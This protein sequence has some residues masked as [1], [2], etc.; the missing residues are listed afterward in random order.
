[1]QIFWTDIQFHDKAPNCTHFEAALQLGMKQWLEGQTKLQRE[2][3][4]IVDFNICCYSFKLFFSWMLVLVLSKIMYIMV[5]CHSSHIGSM[6]CSTFWSLAIIKLFV[7]MSHF[8]EII[9]LKCWNSKENF[10]NLCK[11]RRFF[12]QSS[13][14]LQCKFPRI[15]NFFL[16]YRFV[17]PYV[18]PFFIKIQKFYKS[19][20]V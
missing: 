20:S 12:L 6:Y 1:M 3:D 17:E 8:L 4:F 16:S 10:K 2:G 15:D 9:Y 5:F 13:P 19:D 11:P 18:S 7:K 14:P